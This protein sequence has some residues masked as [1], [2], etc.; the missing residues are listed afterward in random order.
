MALF[1]FI[2]TFFFISLAIT[3]LL[4]LLLVY[5]F[6]QRLG[7]LEQKSDNMFEIVNNIVKEL[8]IIRSVQLNTKQFSGFPPLH[9]V[10]LTNK[11]SP[12]FVPQSENNINVSVID[13]S[14]DG[15]IKTTYI[16]DD[17]DED[18]DEDEDDDDDDDDTDDEIDSSFD[19]SDD[20][21]DD[22]AVVDLEDEVV[23]EKFN[24]EIEQNEDQNIRVVHM[25][26][27]I[28][29]EIEDLTEIVEDLAHSAAE[30][31]AAIQVEK[32]G[33]VEEVVKQEIHDNI[34]PY[35]VGDIPK[36]VIRKMSVHDLKTLVITRGLCS[37]PSKMKKPDLIKLIENI[38]E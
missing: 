38:Q 18:D 21:N 37:D 9:P 19:D 3:F 25:E 31:A 20:E 13:P 7:V 5:H 14:M 8:N 30:I 1:K 29:S 22:T 11:M 28:S 35:V 34:Q 12:F 36:D 2:E 4:V 10:N 15:H 27:L 32:I 16:D 23:I 26:E 6:K 33:P 17:D 24:D